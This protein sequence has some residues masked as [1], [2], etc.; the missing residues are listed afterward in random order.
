LLYKLRTSYPVEVANANVGA[1][2]VVVEVPAGMSVGEVAKRA[3]VSTS[4]LRAWE[5]RY[6]VLQPARSSGGHRRYGPADLARVRRMLDLTA[7]GWSTEAAAAAVLREQQ[8][9][10]DVLHPDVPAGSPPVPAGPRAAGP[11]PGPTAVPGAGSAST[12]PAPVAHRLLTVAPAR[13]PSAGPGSA[14]DPDPVATASAYRAARGL[15]SL[16]RTG[17]VAA[18]LVRLVEDLGGTVV[19]ATEAPDHALP[20]DLG[21]GTGVPLLPVADDPLAQ[22]RLERL[23]PGVVEDARRMVDLLRAAG[24]R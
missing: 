2:H 16:Q 1:A 15:L 5:R 6:G 13:L 10:P 9:P 23:L 4:T 3:G 20:I 11:P 18:V 14:V 22:L 12:E 8:V 24:H 21:V 19:A 7:E 17:D